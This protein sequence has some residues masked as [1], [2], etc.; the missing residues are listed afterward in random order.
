MCVLFKLKKLVC[1]SGKIQ[2]LIHRFHQN[3]DF[4]IILYMCIYVSWV[5]SLLSMNMYN[6]YHISAWATML[7]I[8]A[9][10]ILRVVKLHVCILTIE[11]MLHFTDLV[12]NDFS[13]CMSWQFMDSHCTLLA[14]SPVTFTLNYDM[15]TYIHVYT[16]THSRCASGNIICF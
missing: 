5:T 10:P 2:H 12:T 7:C 16:C 15:Y 9:M 4:A 13:S 3:W 6:L 1:G 8:A 11:K 14:Q